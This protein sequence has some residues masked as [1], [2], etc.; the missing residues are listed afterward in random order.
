MTM[1]AVQ[2]KGGKDAGAV[3]ARS[4]RGAARKEARGHGFGDLMATLTR[5]GPAPARPRPLVM[6]EGRAGGLDRPQADEAEDK[7][8]ATQADAQALAAAGLMLALPKGWEAEPPKNPSQA[9]TAQAKTM[10]QADAEGEESA[11]AA[12]PSAT[13][14]MVAALRHRMAAEQAP[15]RTD[16]A[17]VTP[18]VAAPPLAQ[19]EAGPGH[20]RIIAAVEVTV[21][22]VTGDAPMAQM[23]GFAESA[24]ASPVMPSAAPTPSASPAQQISAALAPAAITLPSAGETVKVLKLH[25]QPEHLG[26]V[27]VTL[28]RRGN[29]LHVVLATESPEAQRLIAR[30]HDDLRQALEALGLTLPEGALV[31]SQRPGDTGQPPVHGGASFMAQH[32][33]GTEARSGGHGFAAAAPSRSGEDGDGGEALA[34]DSGS[35]DRAGVYL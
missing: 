28:K 5:S 14:V 30:D 21:E 24:S 35:V 29:A 4:A 17:A 25:L 27:E 26:T 8:D 22:P 20:G 3:V 10:P 33:G 23:P 2:A 32:G 9:V 18:E 1:D 15:R 13:P 12:F 16:E 6:A 34:D 7:A 31:I 19:T 11:R